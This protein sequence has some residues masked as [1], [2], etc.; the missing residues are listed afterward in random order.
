MIIDP[1]A[2]SIEGAVPESE[3]GH[4]VPTADARIRRGG[5]PD[6]MLEG[7]VVAVGPAVDPLTHR[8]P[9]WISLPATSNLPVDLGVDVTLVLERPAD[10][11]SVPVTAVLSEGAERFVF[12]LKDGSFTRTEIVI[13]IR[14]D[15]FVQVLDGLYNG[16][17]V[18]ATGAELV[19]DTP[20]SPAPAKATAPD[21]KPP[22]APGAG[23]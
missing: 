6:L 2:T 21:S 23:K 11:K 19:R 10:V 15:R 17:Q 20:G 12:K 16:E 4:V 1:T 14:D 7:S 3:F 8:F 18:V 5:R 9:V 13:G 22:A